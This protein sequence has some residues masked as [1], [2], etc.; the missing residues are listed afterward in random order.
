MSE[1]M[2]IVNVITIVLLIM[3]LLYSTKL[4]KRIDLFLKSR[5]D[6]SS[7]FRMFDTTIAQ[8]QEHTSTLAAEA[9]GISKDLQK[10]AD[11]AHLLLQ[12]LRQTCVRAEKVYDKAERGLLRLQK[13]QAPLSTEQRQ[14]YISSS[15]SDAVQQVSDAYV[16]KTVAFKKIEEKETDVVKMSPEE[17]KRKEQMLEKML[18]KASSLKKE[19]DEK[20]ALNTVRNTDEERQPPAKAVKA[21]NSSLK[22]DKGNIND[23]G[24]AIK[25]ALHAMGLENQKPE[26]TAR[27]KQK[28]TL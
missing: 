21:T 23:A 12:D 11:E 25:R 27:K 2:L 13:G 8:A 22:A 20:S 26:K 9:E 14:D 17:R 10:S 1:L 15:D 3:G 4:I 18:R 24:E 16:D 5:E 6:L 19:R 7:L 28:E